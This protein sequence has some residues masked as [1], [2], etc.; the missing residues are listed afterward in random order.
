MFER[1]SDAVVLRHICPRGLQLA[2]TQSRRCAMSEGWR[3]VVR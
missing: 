3:G 1:Y 2:S